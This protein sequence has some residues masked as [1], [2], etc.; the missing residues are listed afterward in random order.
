MFRQGSWPSSTPGDEIQGR[1]YHISIQ[2]G[3]GQPETT[4]AGSV[5]SS[6]KPGR[7]CKSIG[8]SPSSMVWGSKWAERNRE[9]QLKT[10]PKPTSS[11]QST[12]SRKQKF[13]E[14]SGLSG[15]SGLNEEATRKGSFETNRPQTSEVGASIMFHVPDGPSYISVT[16]FRDL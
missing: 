2:L 13:S 12:L 9:R 6:M 11:M 5:H 3:I 8:K 16:P 1:Q 10:T 15:A 14:A 7:D 4:G